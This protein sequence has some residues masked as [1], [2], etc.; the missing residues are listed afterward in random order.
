MARS[1]RGPLASGFVDHYVLS[2]GA[3][4]WPG[5]VRMICEVASLK[6]GGIEIVTLGGDGGARL[7]FHI[8]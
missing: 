8:L 2:S 6:T 7:A 4:N 5:R 3:K 1:A